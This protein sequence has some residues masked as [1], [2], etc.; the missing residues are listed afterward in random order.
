MGGG[1]GLLGGVTNMLLGSPATPATPDYTG[2][3][4]E[5][6]QGNAVRV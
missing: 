5:T 3:A 1:G 2:A 4:K 6:A